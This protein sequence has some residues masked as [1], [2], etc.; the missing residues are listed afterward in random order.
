MISSRIRKS[1]MLP[2]IVL[3][4]VPVPVVRV[5]ALH[6]KDGGG[7]K[8]QNGRVGLCTVH[9]WNLVGGEKVGG[10]H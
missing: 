4:L 10:G 7:N 8:E 1:L 6:R 9:E 2:R 5:Q 3:V